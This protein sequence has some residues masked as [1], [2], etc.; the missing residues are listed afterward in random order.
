[1]NGKIVAPLVNQK[2]CEI[3]IAICC[4]NVRTNRQQDML[5]LFIHNSCLLDMAHPTSHRC[6]RL[7][8]MLLYNCCIYSY[9]STHKW[10][11]TDHIWIFDNKLDVNLELYN[12]HVKQT[13]HDIKRP[14]NL[15]ATWLRFY[16]QIKIILH[17]SPSFCSSRNEP[18]MVLFDYREVH[19][20]SLDVFI[21][22]MKS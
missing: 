20:P 15:N 10:I 1:M 13:C 12:Q 11:I 16:T 4:E 9:R 3:W 22:L 21:I 17:G 2:S 6:S 5:S 14:K 18:T 7:A 19:F 8:G